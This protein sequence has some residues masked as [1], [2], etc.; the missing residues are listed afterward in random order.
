MEKA[1]IIP[2]GD[3]GYFAKELHQTL[4]NSEFINPETQKFPDGEIYHALG[5]NPKGKNII[6]V[7]GTI[8]NHHTLE[9]YDLACA[10][11]KYG[12]ATVTMLV[13]YFGYSTMERSTEG[14]FEVVK[15]KT[16]AR[17]LSAVPKAYKGNTI[18]MMDLHADITHYFEGTIQPSHQ[19][20]KPI[21]IECI[22]ELGIENT[23]LAS[24][25]TGRAKWVESLATEMKM[26]AAVALKSRISG[27]E[28]EL[29]AIS[30]NVKNKRVIIFDDMI[31]TG[32][33]LI[34]AAQAY[35]N[36]GASEIYVIATHGILPGQALKRLQD[37][38]LF[39]QVIVTDTHK[40]TQELKKIHTDGFFQVK[41][42]IPIF[43]KAITSALSH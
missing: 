43:A 30:G 27:S 11:A 33:S 24:P 10:A 13:P 20:S 7:G 28:T 36:A 3:Y 5:I 22:K 9:I 2:I 14:R 23:V 39:K 4:Q 26:P 1:Y 29:K 12:A 15:A 32:G 6:L 42:I 8:D 40:N 34:G 37:S 18:M 41:S 21:V 25:D 31:R 17:L 19:H 16:R 35:K 38:E